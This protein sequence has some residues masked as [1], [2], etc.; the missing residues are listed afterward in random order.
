MCQH[1]LRLKLLFLILQ[2]TFSEKRS[3]IISENLI[4]HFWD[5][6]SKITR[7]Q[8]FFLFRKVYHVNLNGKLH[9]GINIRIEYQGFQIFR[10]EFGEWYFST[11]GNSRESLYLSTCWCISASLMAFGHSW[12]GKC[13]NACWA[14]GSPSNCLMWKSIT[15]QTQIWK[16]EILDFSDNIS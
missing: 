13:I 8:I 9:C 14:K 5:K 4:F 3:K 7:S 11:W 10:C 1:F 6:T 16:S 12:W 2:I 15:P